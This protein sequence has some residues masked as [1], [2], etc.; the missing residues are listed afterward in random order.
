MNMPIGLSAEDVIQSKELYQQSIDYYWFV[1]EILCDSEEYLLHNSGAAA[2]LLAMSNRADK[3]PLFQSAEFIAKVNQVNNSF[4]TTL[5]NGCIA[6]SKA[7]HWCATNAATDI[8]IL[9]IKNRNQH[10]LAKLLSDCKS[11]FTINNTEHKVCEFFALSEATQDSRLLSDASVLK[12]LSNNDT[13]VATDAAIN[14]DIYNKGILNLIHNPKWV[15]RGEA[16]KPEVLNSIYKG[17]HTDLAAMPEWLALSPHFLKPESVLSASNE[18]V[19][20]LARNP[21]WI[22]SEAAQDIRV[23]KLDGNKVAFLAASFDEWLLSPAGQ[24]PKVL[25]LVY[26]NQ[27]KSY[28]VKKALLS[29]AWVKSPAAG[30]PAVLKLHSSQVLTNLCTNT[31]WIRTSHSQK[32][33]LLEL[34]LN[35]LNNLSRSQIWLKTSLAQD[36]ELMSKSLQACILAVKCKAWRLSDIAFHPEMMALKNT[37]SESSFIGASALH[38]DWV[39]ELSK[40]Q[41]AFECA[42][43]LGLMNEI[44]PNSGHFEHVL[45]ALR[46]HRLPYPEIPDNYSAKLISNY[47]QSAKEHFEYMM[48]DALKWKAFEDTQNTLISLLVSLETAIRISPVLKDEHLNNTEQLANEIANLIVNKFHGVVPDADTKKMF[49][50]A[51]AQVESTLNLMTLHQNI[52]DLECDS[53][54]N[55]VSIMMY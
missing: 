29:N 38:L 21:E 32:K 2:K 13:W 46:E 39:E 11:T 49:P 25:D 15:A 48:E 24:D 28:I 34:N 51:V 1:N 10:S 36:H 5:A 37:T 22:K 55:E 50:G 52:N 3:V 17:N 14:P 54:K 33:E 18:I 30:N 31:N 6:D 19:S 47:C 53:E 12:S 42:L 20:G 41:D 44:K 16:N 23:L 40:R 8:N 4:L 26:S 43:Q 45:K 35:S 9:L 7:G 27:G